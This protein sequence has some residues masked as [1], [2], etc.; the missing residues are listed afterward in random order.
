MKKKH[1]KR[2][3]GIAVCKAF[4]LKNSFLNIM[5][6]FFNERAVIFHQTIV[7]PK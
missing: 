6:H 3:F 1:R 7:Y 4:A 2:Y 5:R